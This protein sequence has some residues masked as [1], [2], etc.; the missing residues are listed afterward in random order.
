MR[1]CLA[2]SFIVF[3][4]VSVAP[5]SKL[6]AQVSRQPTVRSEIN[7][8]QNAALNCGMN[9]NVLSRTEFADC[10]N[11]FVTINRQQLSPS[12]PFEFGLYV[13]AIEIANIRRM[14]PDTDGVVAVWHKRAANIM[15]AK[16][17]TLDDFCKAISGSTCDLEKMREQTFNLEPS[18][19]N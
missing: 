18:R 4:I 12:D 7:R 17:L 14:T 11:T 9:T 13:R 19:P 5:Q 6:G 2:W 15:G 3:S 8:G 16:K 10:V 1:G